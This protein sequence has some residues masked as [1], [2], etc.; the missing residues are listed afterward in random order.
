MFSLPIEK[1][2]VRNQNRL[3]FISALIENRGCN[4]EIAYSKLEAFGSLEQKI[5]KLL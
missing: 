2:K 5:F 4:V 3:I 1:I